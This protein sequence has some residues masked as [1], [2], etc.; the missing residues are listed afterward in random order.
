MSLFASE[1]LLRR[2]TPG[3]RYI[4]GRRNDVLH[5]CEKARVS[6]GF[7]DVH[8]IKLINS[9]GR[10]ALLAALHGLVMWTGWGDGTVCN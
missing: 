4:V 1:L 7:Y 9:C 2:F 6:R 8:N 3:G 5:S 10:F